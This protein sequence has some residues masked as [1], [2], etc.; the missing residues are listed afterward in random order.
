[1]SNMFRLELPRD[2]D[3]D[4]FERNPNLNNTILII[5]PLQNCR[6]SG[7]KAQ[8]YPAQ[9]PYS[10]TRTLTGS[11]CK[12]KPSEILGPTRIRIQI[13]DMSRIVAENAADLARN[14]ACDQEDHL[15]HQYGPASVAESARAAGGLIS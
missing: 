4:R 9:T 3:C 13:I 6:G 8:G 14:M 2:W 10:Q 12:Y 7:R 5:L 11:A 15:F 1:M